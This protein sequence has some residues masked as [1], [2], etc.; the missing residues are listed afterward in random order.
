ML[1][2]PRVFDRNRESAYLGQR[3]EAIL[4][5]APITPVP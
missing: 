2:S 5:Y 3:A 4:L 1:P